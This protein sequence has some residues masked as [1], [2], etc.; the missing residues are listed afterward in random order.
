MKSRKT[1]FK[2]ILIVAIIFITTIAIL[3]GYYVGA[4]MRLKS[5]QNNYIVED[6]NKNTHNSG[7][8]IHFLNTGSSDAILIE[9]QGHFALIDAAEDSDNPRGFADLELIGYEQEVLSYI[10]KVAGDAEGIVR[11]DFILGTHAHSDHI[12]GFDT[13]ILDEDIIIDKAYLKEYRAD[14]IRE[15]EREKWDNQ[16][17]YD[18]MVDAL[19]ARGIPI[20]SDIPSDSFMLGN[21][22]IQIY[23]GDYIQNRT[24]I[25]E[26][27][28]SMG[29]LVSKGDKKAF[30]AGDINNY[31][32]TEVKIGEAIGKIDLLKVGH[33]GY[34][35]STTAEF[36][37]HTQPN[38]AILTND[39][40]RADRKILSRLV[41][42]SKSSIYDTY[43]NDG[44]IA[45]FTNDSIKLYNNIMES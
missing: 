45:E 7:D 3:A 17:V 42:V 36:L 21:F 14:I 30:L 33:H 26:N 37:R 16:E 40:K 9:S 2:V 22:T 11:L 13:I 24:N 4:F 29:V 38:I 15:Y 39:I 19:T 1:L 44:I 27:E 6:F 5:Y 8:L 20:V 28:N 31:L 43:S 18:Q 23:N 34:S 32:D 12:G 10:K 35:H 41:Y 25:G